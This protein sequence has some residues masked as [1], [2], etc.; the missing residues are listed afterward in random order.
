MPTSL[1][2]S[3]PGPSSSPPPLTA[4]PKLPRR[5]HGEG[6]R[7]MARWP[8][9][10]VVAR[11][12]AGVPSAF[13]TAASERASL[14]VIAGARPG[15]AARTASK[16][17][18]SASSPAVSSTSS[19][20]NRATTRPSQTAATRSRLSSTTVPPRSRSR[21]S[22]ACRTVTTSRSGAPPVSSRSL[23]LAGEG[24]HASG[25]RRRMRRSL[26]LL[27][28]VDRP[29]PGGQGGR[30]HRDDDLAAGAPQP[31]RV[32][33]APDRTV[34]ACRGSGPPSGPPSPA[35]STGIRRPHRP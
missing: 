33:G 29:G 21:F 17:T 13:E 1:P 15:S 28:P 19:S 11:R 2:S 32:T 16:S 4:R 8:S 34:S 27:A 30:L 14:D 20:T 5:A 22:R 10:S 12:R 24:G 23:D 26:E 18:R 9:G 3:P 31:G 6:V 25:V 35:R 7:P